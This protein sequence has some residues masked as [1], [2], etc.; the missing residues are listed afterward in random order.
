[1]SKELEY[2][3]INVKTHLIATQY[4][5]ASWDIIQRELESIYPK[6]TPNSEV[7]EALKNANLKGSKSYE[8]L[9]NYIQTTEQELADINRKGTV[10]Y[11]TGLTEECEIVLMISGTD[12][13]VEYT[14][15]TS[16]AEIEMIYPEENKFII[17]IGEEY[18]KAL[19]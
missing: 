19:C 14:K 18:S 17:Y 4:M 2:A 7:M 16:N 13:V 9:Y 3:I 5:G 11:F 6:P 8:I 10:G 12:E 1:M 15:E